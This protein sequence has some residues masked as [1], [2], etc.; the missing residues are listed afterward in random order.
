MRAD[1]EQRPRRR[2]HGFPGDVPLG[3]VGGLDGVE[4]GRAQGGCCEGGGHGE[5]QQQGDYA[6]GCGGCVGGGEVQAA[7]DAGAGQ[8]KGEACIS[9]QVAQSG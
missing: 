4:R 1:G 2:G 7:S 9:G 6:G 3:V 5:Q 8:A